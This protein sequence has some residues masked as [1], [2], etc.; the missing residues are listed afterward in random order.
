MSKTV[1]LFTAVPVLDF[2]EDL[3]RGMSAPREQYT[4]EVNPDCERLLEQ[5]PHQGESDEQPRPLGSSTER[6][7]SLSAQE[8]GRGGSEQNKRGARRS[9]SL[10]RLSF[11]IKGPRPAPERI[12]LPPR[13]SSTPPSIAHSETQLRP[14]PESESEHLTEDGP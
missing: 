11:V 12:Y 5:R 2:I 10:P 8:T 7:V 3:S 4:L 14:E 1:N 6:R 9:E 13:A